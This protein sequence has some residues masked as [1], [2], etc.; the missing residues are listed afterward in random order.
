MRS[1]LFGFLSRLELIAFLSVSQTRSRPVWPVSG[2]KYFALWAQIC[3]EVQKII[4]HMQLKL[5]LIAVNNE[6]SAI[7]HN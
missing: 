7:N 6:D 2:Q 5:R 1:F 4:L 3:L